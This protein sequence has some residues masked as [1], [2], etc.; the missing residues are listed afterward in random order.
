MVKT[1]GSCLCGQLRVEVDGEPLVMAHCC[2][3]DCQKASGGGHM[4]IARFRKEDVKVSGEYATF[5]IVAKSGNTNYRHFCP[6]CGG[7]VFGT[8]SG[9]PEA[10]NVNI[11]VLE[12]QSWFKPQAAIFTRDRQ[13]WDELPPELRQFE[14]YPES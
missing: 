3:K 12:D 9:R 2:C 8:N 10:V 11:G 13:E 6:E 5:G 1:T 7:R 14:E 4:T